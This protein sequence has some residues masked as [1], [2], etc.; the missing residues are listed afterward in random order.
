MPTVSVVVPTY[1]RAHHLEQAIKSVLK[2][3]FEDFE[4]IVVDDGSTD[5]TRSVVQSFDDP[6][7]QYHVHDTN[8]GGSAARNTGIEE[9]TGKYVAFLDDDDEWLPEKLRL[10]V[11]CLESR[12][13]EW[14]AAYCDYDVVRDE[15]SLIGHLPSF[16][17]DRW[18]GAISKPRP[19]GG[20]ELIPV[21]LARNLPHGGASTLMVRR[22]I[23]E[24]IGGFDPEFRRHQDHE[25]LIRVLKN[26]NLAYVDGT[27]VEKHGT[28]RPSM[29]AIEEGKRALFSRFSSEIAAAELNGYDITGIHQFDLARFYIM[30]GEFLKGAKN[31]AGAKTQIPELLR[32]TCIGLYTRLTSSRS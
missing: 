29:T 26:G 17:L 18:P 28:G 12:G 21:L 24:E 5:E 6:R 2:Q 11:A 7:V 25:F 4:L 3:E 9:S 27:L 1:N 31:L 20:R 22:D 8:K 32:A 10:Q 14:V 23:V 13:D 16:V 15:D 19:E 30:N